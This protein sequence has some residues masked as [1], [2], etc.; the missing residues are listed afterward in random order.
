V[1]VLSRNMKN[2]PAA[3]LIYETCL[4]INET[5]RNMNGK[6]IKAGVFVEKMYED[7]EFWYPYLR[8]KEAGI[9]PDVIAPKKGEYAGKHGLVATA[10]IA[11]DAA[12]GK[13]YDLIVVPG[14]YS[15][16]HMRRDKNMIEIV[17]RHGQANRTLAVICHGPWMLVSAGL[18]KGRRLTSFFSIK[19]DLIAAGANW[20][21][22][23]VV[24]DGNLITAQSPDDLPRLMPVVL[25]AIGISSAQPVG[26]AR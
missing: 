2:Y 14:G 24:R 13:T 20:I 25:D 6:N 5:E 26:A 17:R 9:E 19:D 10:T 22:E 16:D 1:P 12:V 4:I 23:G 11:S 18:A 21:D 3:P 7:L 8:L 15:P